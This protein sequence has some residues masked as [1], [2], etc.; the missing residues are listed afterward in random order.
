M[1]VIESI[2]QKYTGACPYAFPQDIKNL[3][4]Y[5]A[6]PSATE[7]PPQWPDVKFC[8]SVF[9]QSQEW[10]WKTGRILACIP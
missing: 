8:V 1:F 2:N 4:H 5:I 9:R 3:L 7:Y 6:K 10:R